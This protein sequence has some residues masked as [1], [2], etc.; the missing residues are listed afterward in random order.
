MTTM[1]GKKKSERSDSL[2]SKNSGE[3]FFR[4]PRAEFF[5]E[6]IQTDAPR[7]IG[8]LVRNSAHIMENR[9]TL[10]LTDDHMQGADLRSGDYVVVEQQATYPEGS[11]LAVQLGNRQFIRR[12]TRVGGR[13]HLQCDP[14]SKQIMIVE[15]NTPDF[16]ILGQVVQVIREIK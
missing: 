13:I 4:L 2:L 8:D 12:Y 15:E 9:F 3:E 16:H 14:P 10:Q 11:I 5:I 1:N 7:Q 6:D